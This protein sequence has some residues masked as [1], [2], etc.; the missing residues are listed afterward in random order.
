MNFAVLPPEV[1][2]ARMHLGA[3]LGPMLTAAAAWDGLAAE[4]GSAATS[5]SVVTTGLT[6]SLWLGPSSAAMADAAAPYLGWLNAAANQAEQ[7]AVQVR[8]AA[9]AFEAALAA[10]VHPALISA[11]RSQFVS[12]VLSNLFGQ[13]ATAIADAEIHYEQMCARDVAAMF[14]YY[15]GASAAVS[16]LTPFPSTLRGLANLA[17]PTA[18]AYGAAAA[19]VTAAAAAA[20]DIVVPFRNVGL[21]NVGQ[22]N[23]GNA[24]IG[25]FNFGS[26]NTGSGNIGSGNIGSGNVGFGNT[27]NGNSGIGLTGDHLRGFGGMNSGTGNVGFF[28][29]GTG[30]VGIGNSGSGNWGIGNSGNGY[31]TATTTPASSTWAMSTPAL[32]STWRDCSATERARC[33]TSG[34]PTTAS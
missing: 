11:N 21:A 17:G 3:G 26:G 22:G 12:L 25:D 19:T 9:A 29:S 8:L 20:Q 23:L 28:N 10:T 15:S 34:W 14:D 31:N 13:N 6:G 1:K 2:S 32:S 5:F 33:S 30:N 4:L 16:T 27:G 7:A 18:G 24:N